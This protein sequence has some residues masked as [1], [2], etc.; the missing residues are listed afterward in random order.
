[1]KV[2]AGTN[3]I[4][5]GGSGLH[6]FFVLKKFGSTTSMANA[7]VGGHSL[8]PN[9]PVTCRIKLHNPHSLCYVNASVLAVVHVLHA[10]NA[11][12]GR[13]NFLDRIMAESVAS[14][15]ALRLGA[16]LMFRAMLPRWT[17][18]AQQRD[19]AEYLL[20]LLEAT[21]LLQHTW[22]AR[23][24]TGHGRRGF[25]GGP[26][27]MMTILN[28]PC[29]LQDVVNAWEYE[30]QLQ[31]YLVEVGEHV[32]IQLGRYNEEDKIF[33]E[34]EFRETVTLPM[35]SADGGIERVHFCPTAAVIHL[36]RTIHSG[37]YQAVL[38]VR[39]QWWLSDD[40]RSAVLEHENSR[41]L[42]NVYLIF[43]SKQ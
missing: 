43:L 15:S 39:D 7:S 29:S 17:Y 28:R 37:H 33:T 16:N 5:E 10:A 2:S 4:G 23:D 1:M 24:A 38:K 11:S 34:V 18:D 35:Q 42:A 3:E 36:G 41:S 13:M 21:N 27:V 30:D 6:R 14:G 26:L 32:I 12:L 20:A 31:H 22:V 19:A 8:V 25:Q 9:L 40:D